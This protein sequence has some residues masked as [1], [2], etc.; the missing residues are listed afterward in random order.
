[1]YTVTMKTLVGQE[2]VLNVVE[3]RQNPNLVVNYPVDIPPGLL[4]FTRD[5]YDF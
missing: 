3:I 2:V 1:M 4:D 5:N